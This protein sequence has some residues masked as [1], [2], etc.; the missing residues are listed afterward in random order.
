MK[1]FLSGATGA[2]L[3]TC[4]CV[5][6]YVGC[7]DTSARAHASGSL[8]ADIIIMIIIK[9]I[10]CIHASV[11]TRAHTYIHLDT[12]HEQ[13]ARGG[14]A[15]FKS[16][17][18]RPDNAPGSDCCSCN[19]THIKIYHHSY[20]YLYIFLKCIYGTRCI[21]IYN[22]YI[23]YICV[24]IYLPFCFHTRPAE[25]DLLLFFIKKKN[26][27]V[28]CGIKCQITKLMCL[29]FKLLESFVGKMLCI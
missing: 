14:G 6:V 4:V 24:R 27:R 21:Y 19:T 3:C 18:G 26:Q 5:C 13:S 17:R 11:Y 9:I 12:L 10:I 28:F 20:S 22:S 8:A 1:L 7:E 29:V 25:L 23:V 15:A 2:R 16:P